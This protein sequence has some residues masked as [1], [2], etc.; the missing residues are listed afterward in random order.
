MKCWFGR[1]LT[2]TCLFFVATA[3][4]ADTIQWSYAWTRSPLSVPSDANG[5]GGISLTLGQGLPMTGSSDITAVNLS[6]FSSAPVGTTDH[7]T[8]SPFNLGLTVK[9]T[10][11]GQSA[12][13]SFLG[14]FNGTLTPTSS[15]IKATYDQSPHQLSI[16]SNLY[17]IQLTSYVA[18]G[19][20]DSTAV[21]SIGAHVSVSSPRSGGPIGGGGGTS[22]G[23]GSISDVP[24][25]AS[26]LLAGLASP[27]LCL[28][29]WRRVQAAKAVALVA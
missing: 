27:A 22:G 6:T 24:E 13:T 2:L 5:T 21:G 29:C 3:A 11:S 7:F 25:P 20:P 19:I 4:R 23:G 14:V 8:N 15:S 16:G 18:P 28:V 12:T 1:L 17:T 9:D 10:A 26:L